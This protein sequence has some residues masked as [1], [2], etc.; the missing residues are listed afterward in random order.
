[1]TVSYNAVCDMEVP[2]RSQSSKAPKGDSGFKLNVIKLITEVTMP[3]HRSIQPNHAMLR[4][5]RFPNPLRK[6]VG[7][8]MP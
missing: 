2:E 1:M 8:S 6:W 7:V 3:S 4:L 5:V